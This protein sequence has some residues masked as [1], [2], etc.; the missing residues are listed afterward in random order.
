MKYATHRY[1]TLGGLL[2]LAFVGLVAAQQDVHPVL[3]GEV[4]PDSAAVQAGLKP[5]DR[6]LTYDGKSMRSP[7]ALQAAQDNTFGKNE[8]A[9]S[10]QR[11]NQTLML[12]AQRGN[13]GIQVRPELPGASVVL[14]EE[15]KLALKTQNTVEA[16]SRWAAAAKTAMD[17]GDV[18][19]TAWLQSRIG[20]IHENE[21]RWKEAGESY[22]TAL[23][24]FKRFE[25]PAAQ[26]RSLVALGR[27][28]QNLND[29]TAA[30]LAPNS[31]ELARDINSLG[32]IALKQR[33]FPEALPLFKRAITIVEDQRWQIRS[34]EARAL[35]LA[36]HTES[37]T[38][39]MRVQ[40]AL[41]DVPAAFAIAE[42]ARARSLLESLGEVG[43]EI[44]H[45]VDPVLLERERLLQREL[46]DKAYRQT[47]VLAA[48]H[49]SAQALQ[50]KNDLDA[51][52]V[53][54]QQLQNEIR[55]ASPHYAALTQPQ[56]LSLAEIQREVLDDQTLLL[57]YVLGEESSHLFAITPESIRSFE[58]PGRNEI[59]KAAR[60]VM[61]L[62]TVTQPVPGETLQ[63]RRVRI[64]NAEVTYGSAVSALSHMLV[65]PVAGLL[66][67]Q[68]LLIVADGAL[69]YVPFAA[70]PLSSGEP[71]IVRH[72]VVSLPSASVVALQRR[73][74]H[75]RR[76]AEKLVAVLADPVFDTGDP[77]LKTRGPRQ[78]QGLSTIPA[79]RGGT[80]SRLPFTREEAEAI[81]AVA[82]AGQSVKALDFAASRS[83][84]TS[85]DLAQYRIVH[86]ATH[87]VLDTDHPELSG[88]VLSLVDGQG[89]PQDGF[90]RLHEVYNLNWA[91]DLV[92]LSACQT[93]LGKEIKGEGL[94][95]LTR[96]FMYAGAKTV[97]ASL[98]N[99]NDSITAEFMKRF[100]REMIVNG[101]PPASALRATQIEM[102]KRKQWQ[103]PY[104]WAGFVVQGDWK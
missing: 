87:A 24:L 54:Y 82:P 90:L 36:Q 73:E 4:L 1:G 71:L 80:L 100:Y 11:E 8:V 29:L 70:L 34:T 13:L 75:N 98:W 92:V 33:R 96:G 15:G 6:I 85:A 97:V 48:P 49:T 104:Y 93:G 86:L 25:D 23:E 59:E 22:L 28:A 65:G 66:S 2:V 12:I 19:A 51:L 46:N 99:V 69:H 67:D 88:I 78:P 43:T 74:S 91:A 79:L 103:S 68:R 83:T 61:E 5:G 39:L 52:L 50:V 101:M 64:N 81:T 42:R 102:S 95:G 9:L 56:P 37:Y 89:Q 18:P 62:M 77:R 47:Q 84:A 76:R 44:R 20:E 27:C 26:S 7:M 3:I 30:K 38:G 35:L 72:E 58:L 94:V 45:G 53:R 21:R 31:L 32:D 41:N 10:V 14:Y 55:I 60:R 40:L 57:E 63:Q 16:I 17:A